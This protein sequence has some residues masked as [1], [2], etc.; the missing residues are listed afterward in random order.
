[1]AFGQLPADRHFN[2]VGEA[3]QDVADEAAFHLA[4][5]PVLALEQLHGL[6]IERPARLIVP[7]AGQCDQRPDILTYDPR[8][9]HPD[10]P[11][12]VTDTTSHAAP[13]ERR[14]F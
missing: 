1:E 9:T 4:Q 7:L 11:H 13:S 6:E 2:A 3:A 5:V 14:Q 12:S 10:A 8:F